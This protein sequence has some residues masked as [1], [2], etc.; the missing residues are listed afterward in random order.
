MLQP[1]KDQ[2]PDTPW[3]CH[4]YDIDPPV[5]HPWP[6]R[7]S[8]GSPMSRICGACKTRTSSTTLVSR[9]L[10]SQ[11][12]GTSVGEVVG[13][14]R[15]RSERRGKRRCVHREGRSGVNREAAG[16]PVK[17]FDRIVS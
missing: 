11:R 2:Y 9:I 15:K 1:A 3:D 6:D 17:A 16:F 12:S 13:H 14:L 5:N 7:Q 4:I 10:G 8:Y